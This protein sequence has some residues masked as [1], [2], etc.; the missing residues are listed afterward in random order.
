MG[1]TSAVAQ[2]PDYTGEESYYLTPRQQILSPPP[3]IQSNGAFLTVR[4]PKNISCMVFGPCLFYVQSVPGYM[5]QGTTNWIYGVNGRNKSAPLLR[6]DP[7]FHVRSP[8]VPPLPQISN[9]SGL[10]SDIETTTLY[11]NGEL[12]LQILDSMKTSFETALK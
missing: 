7:E 6:S 9:T 3:P 1:L 4:A 2:R 12:C 11:T 10:G 8:G 5:T